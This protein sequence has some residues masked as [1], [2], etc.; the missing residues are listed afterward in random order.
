[1]ERAIEMWRD[2]QLP[3]LNLKDPWWG[4][5]LGHWTQEE[6]EEADLAVEGPPLR[7]RREADPFAPAVWEGIGSK[8]RS[9]LT[10]STPWPK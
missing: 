9:V 3:S 1:M 4:Y 8:H 2:L 5:S 7:D 10:W 6:E